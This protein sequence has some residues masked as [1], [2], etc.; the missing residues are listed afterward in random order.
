MFTCVYS[1]QEYLI[2]QCE[3]GKMLKL[4]II[5]PII[6][7]HTTKR[8]DGVKVSVK[9]LT[10]IMENRDRTSL[11]KSLES[12]LWVILEQ[13]LY[14][15]LQIAAGWTCPRQPRWLMNGRRKTHIHFVWFHILCESGSD[16]LDRRVAGNNG[17][18]KLRSFE[19]PVV[20][21]R[22]TITNGGPF[23][24]LMKRNCLIVSGE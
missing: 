8:T 13:C 7:L 22:M 11:N 9:Q 16:I 2:W 24:M 4:L 14:S 3:W 1:K 5:L 21:T 20:T 19:I 6:T 17:L 23:Y 15:H 18:H 10:L 12:F